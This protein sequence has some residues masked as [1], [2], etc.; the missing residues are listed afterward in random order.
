M[1]LFIS[2]KRQIKLLSISIIFIAVYFVIIYNY[3]ED[4]KFLIKALGMSIPFVLL[5][6]PTFFIHI[7]YLICDYKK[8][9]IL[10]YQ[11]A[12]LIISKN[13]SDEIIIRFDEIN[14]IL[15]HKREIEGDGGIAWFT[16]HD[17]SYTEIRYSGN[18]KI[19]VTC[20]CYDRQFPIPIG[21]TLKRRL[22]PYLKK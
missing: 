5:V 22:I 10:D 18:K 14:E 21:Y 4:E 16:W 17:Y 9:I 7:Q 6:F 20:F 8:K 3:K 11:S 19:K 13:G 1:E 12:K 15:F 2:L